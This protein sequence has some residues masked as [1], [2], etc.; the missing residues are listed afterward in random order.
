M[1]ETYICQLG[2]GIGFDRHIILSQLLLDLLDAL[3]DVLRLIKKRIVKYPRANEA[4]VKAD[5]ERASE[6][7]KLG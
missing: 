5:G 2:H 7:G 1:P 4:V 3:R 6:R